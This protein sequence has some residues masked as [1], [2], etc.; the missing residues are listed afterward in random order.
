MILSIYSALAAAFVAFDAWQRGH[1]GKSVSWIAGTFI[2]YPAALPFYLAN[3]P[4]KAGEV[5]EGGRP[6]NVLK[7][8]ALVW[9]VAMVIFGIKV[10]FRWADKVPSSPVAS[11]LDGTIS[12]GLVGLVWFVP[13]TVALV[14]GLFVKNSSVESGPS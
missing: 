9:T 2:C 5:R 14:L 1:I 10:L 12:M 4:L 11:A 8:F 3:R 7:Y 13:V 6:W